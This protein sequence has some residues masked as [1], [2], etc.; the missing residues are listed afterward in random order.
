[1]ADTSLIWKQSSCN[2]VSLSFYDVSGCNGASFFSRFCG[3]GL[4]VS[5]L[6][7]S[8]RPPAIFRAIVSIVI[9]SINGVQRTWTSAHILEKV[10]K[11]V[12]PSIANSNAPSSIMHPSIKSWICASFSHLAPSFILNCFAFAV[13]SSNLAC[14][15]FL[16]ASAAI[17]F[18]AAQCRRCNVFNI[19]AFALAKPKRFVKS[20]PVSFKNSKPTKLCAS[21]INDF[22]HGISVMLSAINVKEKQIAR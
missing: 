20:T 11:R 21:V 9:K 8:S 1:M 7:T 2:G 3:C 10:F 15:F 19:S 18:P 4:F 12:H 5:L 14:Y 16:K 6:L 22:Y 13:S 17:A